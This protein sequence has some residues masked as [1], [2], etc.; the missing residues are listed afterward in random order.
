MDVE[1]KIF[2]YD[3]FKAGF[4]ITP[5]AINKHPLTDL[6]PSEATDLLLTHSGVDYQNLVEHAL[7]VVNGLIYPASASEQGIALY[8]AARPTLKD[9]LVALV[10]FARIAALQ[11]FVI[12]ETLLARAED[13]GTPLREALYLH[14]PVALDGVTPLLVVA[15]FWQPVDLAVTQVGERTLRLDTSALQLE[16]RFLLSSDAYPYPL[17]ATYYDGR[18]LNRELFL[19]NDVL[20]PFLL[21]GNS[22]LVLIHTSAWT[23]DTLPVAPLGLPG[24]YQLSRSEGDLMLFEDGRIA[25][26]HYDGNASSPV[27]VTQ[28]AMTTPARYRTT[29]YRGQ[30]FLTQDARTDIRPRQSRLKFVQAK[31]REA[32]GPVSASKVS[33]SSTANTGSK[34]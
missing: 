27:L 30:R 33:S 19:S 14:A 8:Q 11:T 32:E 9:N 17:M 18:T 20:Y 5:F 24:R 15:G 16:E 28:R 6:L 3:A 13:Y 4:T 25:H 10:S 2:C 21:S 7:F 26:S 22:Q 12:D 34:R 31:K 1:E 29:D 23:F